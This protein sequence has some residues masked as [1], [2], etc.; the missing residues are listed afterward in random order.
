MNNLSKNSIRRL[1]LTGFSFSAVSAILEI[2]AI[3][4]VEQD[5]ET[6]LS[7]EGLLTIVVY[8]VF[9][10]L[11]LILLFLR[12]F[13]SPRL[14]DIANQLERL[15]WIRWLAVAAIILSVVWFYLYSPWQVTLTGPW[16]Q[17]IF[18][19]GLTAWIALLISPHRPLF[20]GREE[21]IFAF[22]LFLF[23][24]IVQ[25]LR[26]LF[27]Q[28]WIY[29]FAVLLGY[30]IIIALAVI[31]LSSFHQRL[32]QSLISWRNRMGWPRWIVIAAA[33]CG[34]A[35]FYVL[36]GAKIY[37][38]NPNL[39]FLFILIELFLIAA[40]FNTKGEHLVSVKTVLIGA[41]SLALISAL[42]GVLI[43]VTNYPFS[44]G[45]VGRGSFLRRLAVIWTAS[46]QLF[47]LHRQS[48]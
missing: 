14:K 7:I 3:F 15:G 42:I 20:T 9:L 18:A 12:F 19:F 26:I 34:P 47:R 8:V 1:F 31:L 44:I 23:P 46:L 30:F 5:W 48:L 41:F 29:R 36:A 10:I 43:P 21:F 32:V 38:G 13:D 33:L 17:L 39:R 22:G 2:T 24:R 4:R 11:G 25:E 27:T 45:L 40:L 6:L 37:V 16:L 28:A 35:I